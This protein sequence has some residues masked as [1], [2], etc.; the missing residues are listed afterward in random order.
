[1]RW[2]EL[3]EILSCEIH[4][5]ASLQVSDISFHFVCNQIDGHKKDKNRRNSTNTD[6][7]KSGDDDD[8]SITIHL[9]LNIHDIHIYIPGLNPETSDETDR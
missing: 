2:C 5:Y 8:D 7:G 1:M 3:L 9:H 6:D 4:S